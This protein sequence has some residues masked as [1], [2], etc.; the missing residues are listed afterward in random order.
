MTGELEGIK[1]S[2]RGLADGLWGAG[3]RTPRLSSLVNYF[4]LGP[5]SAMFLGMLGYFLAK[6][7][8]NMVASL[9]AA[10]T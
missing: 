2:G 1:S 4:A 7:S 3:G 5:A 9:L 8:E 10:A 6:F